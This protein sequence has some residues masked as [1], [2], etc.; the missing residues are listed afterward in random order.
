MNPAII[1]SATDS[2]RAE[3]TSLLPSIAIN[4]ACNIRIISELL[5]LIDVVSSTH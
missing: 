5:G 3:M 4:L 2:L 1:D